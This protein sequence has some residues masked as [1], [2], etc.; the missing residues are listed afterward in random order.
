MARLV[1][2]DARLA[3]VPGRAS[4]LR[5]QPWLRH[6]VHTRADGG[7]RLPD[8]RGAQPPRPPA[9]RPGPDPGRP[10]DRR[11]PGH[12]RHADDLAPGAAAPRG[13][14]AVVLRADQ[15]HL[16]QP[17]PGDADRGRRA[18]AG[19]PGPLPGVDAD[20]RGA[21]GD[22]SR[23]VLPV[24][25]GTA[26][27]GQ[28]PRRLPGPARRSLHLRRVQP[29]RPADGRRCARPGA[30]PR[31]PGRRDAVA[32]H[33]VRDV[34]RGLLLVR[35]A[36]VAEG[37][38]GA[39][40]GR[41]GHLAGVRRRALRRRRA[42]RGRLRPRRDRRLASDQPCP[43]RTRARRRERRLPVSRR[44]RP[45]APQEPRGPTAEP[46]QAVDST[47]DVPAVPDETRSTRRLR[48]ALR[49]RQASRGTSRPS[50][51][52]GATGSR[53]CPGRRS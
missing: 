49:L 41:D 8:R 28:L 24:P 13:L 45:S 27:A 25:D 31:E 7:R 44:R 32:A 48:T 18:L 51:T 29:D 46:A 37:P 30:V 6:A 50:G 40:P 53:R 22:G 10:L 9:A 14:D 36:L 21:R 34:G 1:A 17:L 43:T 15:P 47:S 4:G 20:G 39:L 19:E 38:A 12:G 16:L 2:D 23:D 33:G 11:A 26:L 52:T 3:A 5:L 42:R 35:Q